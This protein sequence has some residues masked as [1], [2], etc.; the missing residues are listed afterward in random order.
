MHGK[1]LGFRAIQFGSAF[2]GALWGVAASRTV[3]DELTWGNMTQKDFAELMETESSVAGE[4]ATQPPV[5]IHDVDEYAE[6]TIE[7]QQGVKVIEGPQWQHES[8]KERDAH[9]RNIKSTMPEG[10][11]LFVEIPSGDVWLIPPGREVTESNGY[12][13]MVGGSWY[14]FMW[15]KIWKW[16]GWQ[17][18]ELPRTARREKKVAHSDMRGTNGEALAAAP[19]GP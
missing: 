14:L 1:R 19:E 11:G 3:A 9:L 8:P 13:H 16:Q 6:W 2:I 17:V 12:K 18:L 5:A 7:D 10:Y 15:D 4:K